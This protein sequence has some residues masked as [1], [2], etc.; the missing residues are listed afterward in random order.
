MAS[1][2]TTRIDA[3]ALALAVRDALQ[4]G[5]MLEALRLMRSASRFGLT[6]VLDALGG[7]QGGGRQ[8]AGS[9]DKAVM[10]P[11]PFSASDA[12]GKLPADVVEALQRGNKIEAIS[13]LRVQTRMGLKEAREAVDFYA[14]LHPRPGDLSPGEVRGSGTSGL[15]A[16]L[17]IA[18]LVGYWLIRRFA[19]Q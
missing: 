12:L 2:N 4:K 17:L 6:G 13:R 11:T 16:I 19:W 9:K 10:T 18:I 8:K 14:L 7:F 15:W 5:R 1:D 3:Q